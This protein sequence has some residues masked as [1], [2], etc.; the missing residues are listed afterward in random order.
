MGILYIMKYNKDQIIEALKKNSVAQSLFGNRL[1]DFIDDS[2]EAYNE[3]HRYYHNLNHIKQIFSLID[4]RSLNL[5]YYEILQIVAIIHDSI[6]YPKTIINGKNNEE[7][8]AEWFMEWFK[9]DVKLS[10][11]KRKTIDLIKN[12]VLETQY[13]KK[14]GTTTISK[15]FNELDLDTLINGDLNTLINNEKLLSKEYQFN[16]YLKYKEGRINFLNSIMKHKLIQKNNKNIL[17]LIEY[18]KN[19]IPHIGIYAGTFDP[20]HVG[21]KN[22]LEKADKL[23]DKVIVSIGYNPE[24]PGRILNSE[25]VSKVIP[26][27]EVD[28]FSGALSEYIKSVQ[29]YAKVTLVRGL[30]NGYDFNYEL[31]QLRFIEDMYGGK[32]SVVFIPCDR[33]YDYISSSAIRSIK[34]V[35][36]KFCRNWLVK[37]Y[38]F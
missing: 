23:F 16:N 7:C 26:F 6:Y 10:L 27:Y 37:D 2:I 32:I 24:K 14:E 28:K 29:T 12:M 1:L 8:S 25:I 9:D 15:I 4:T 3:P 33:E 21:H 36:D 22:I 20:F 17:L 38:P 30:R 5:K 13:T 11:E 19:Y 34:T 18:I 35:D 31:N